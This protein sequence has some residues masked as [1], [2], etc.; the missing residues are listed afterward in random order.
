MFLRLSVAQRWVAGNWL[1]RY[2]AVLFPTFRA[3]LYLYSPDMI[4]LCDKCF[5]SGL[6]IT[7]KLGVV[8]PVPSFGWV[9]VIVANELMKWHTILTSGN[10]GAPDIETRTERSDPPRRISDLLEWSQIQPT[11]LPV[12]TTLTKYII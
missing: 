12:V 11:P 10:S 1:T 2:Y 7:W 8:F 9:G 3:L 6:G 5:D 4:L